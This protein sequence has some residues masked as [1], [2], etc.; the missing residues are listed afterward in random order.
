[1]IRRYEAAKERAYT[2]FDSQDTQIN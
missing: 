2:S 1:M